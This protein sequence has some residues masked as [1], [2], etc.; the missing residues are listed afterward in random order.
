MR[1]IILF[2]AILF[3][4]SC[5]ETVKEQNVVDET[6]TSTPEEKVVES[7]YAKLEGVPQTLNYIYDAGYLFSEDI[8]IDEVAVFKNDEDKFNFIV[9]LNKKVNFEELQKFTLGLVVYPKDLTVL[10]TEKE[11]RTKSR[12]T[13]ASTEVF[14]LD[15]APVLFIKDFEIGTNE[16]NLIKVYFYNKEGVLNDK[17]LRLTNVKL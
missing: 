13:G 5:K 6:T 8:E 14:M 16:F 7:N 4:A 10:D 9:Y 12:A 1:V 3:F 15:N 2:T 11:K 17:I